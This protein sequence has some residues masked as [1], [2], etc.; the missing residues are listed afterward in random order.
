[1][2]PVDARVRVLQKVLRVCYG[3]RVTVAYRQH[4]I[5]ADEALR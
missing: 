3:D 5:I 2:L 1:L 4:A